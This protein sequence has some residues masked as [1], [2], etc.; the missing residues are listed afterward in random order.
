MGAEEAGA[1]GDENAFEHV[2]IEDFRLRIAGSGSN[3]SGA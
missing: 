1:A 3:R 2:P